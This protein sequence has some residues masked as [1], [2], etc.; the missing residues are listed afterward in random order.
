MDVVIKH[1]CVSLGSSVLFSDCIFSCFF[2]GLTPFR[3]IQFELWAHFIQIL[4]HYGILAELHKGQQASVLSFCA[5]SPG[6]TPLP[7]LPKGSFHE[8]GVAWLTSRSCVTGLWGEGGAERE[9]GEREG[10]SCGGWR[11]GGCEGTAGR[12]RFSASHCFVIVPMAFCPQLS[13]R[14]ATRRD[15]S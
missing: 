1:V 14:K 4:D 6:W 15:R 8:V 9:G 13:S 3:S 7:L 11:R 2:L 5:F 12:R 10:E